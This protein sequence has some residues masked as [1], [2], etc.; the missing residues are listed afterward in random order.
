V[1]KRIPTQN[2]FYFGFAEMRNGN[3][4]SEKKNKNRKEKEKGASLYGNK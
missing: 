4:I 2:D 3:R 1:N